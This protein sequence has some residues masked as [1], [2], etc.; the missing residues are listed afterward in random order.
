MLIS[1]FFTFF[2]KTSLDQIKMQLDKMKAQ[3]EAKLEDHASSLTVKT[4]LKIQ[5]FFKF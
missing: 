1:R 4:V 5:F 2:I 3:L